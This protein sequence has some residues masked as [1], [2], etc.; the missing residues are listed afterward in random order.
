[1]PR[2][3]T[4]PA[5][6]TPFIGRRRAL[7]TLAD[8]FDRG[9]RLVSIV[10]AGGIGKTRLSVEYG[11][12]RAERGDPVRFCELTEQH[13]AEG[14]VTAVARGVGARGVDEDEVV[15]ALRRLRRGLLILDNF[16][17]L[18]AHAGLLAGWLERCPE[19]RVLVTSREVLRLEGEVV[20]ELGPL[21]LS[22]PR[23]EDRPS[24]ALMLWST[25]RQRIDPSYS[26]AG[27]DTEALEEI[28]RRLDGIPLAIELAAARANLM[29]TPQLRDRLNRR[30]DV[31]RQR[32][33][34][35]S[36][37]R[38]TMEGAL[39]WSWD[40]L[41][42]PE[43]EA[44]AQCS[45][46]RGGFSLDA[47]EAVIDLRDLPELLPDL[48]DLPDLPAPEDAPPVLDVLQAL[49]DKS[50][51]RRMEDAPGRLTMYATIRDYGARKLAADPA[52]RRAAER[53]HG[54]FFAAFGRRLVEASL[55]TTGADAL[56]E[57]AADLDNLLAVGE[58]AVSREAPDVKEVEDALDAAVAADA[59]FSTRGPAGGHQELLDALVEVAAEVDA[60]AL[61]R[62]RALRARGLLL[63][64][65]GRIAAGR[66]DLEAAVELAGAEA[67]ER[68]R[69]LLD[70]SWTYLRE[71]DLDRVEALG[72]EA[73]ELARAAGDRQLEGMV[74]GALG[75]PPK[76]RG[77]DARAADLYG[78][79]LSIHRETGNRWYEGLAHTRL[80]ILHLEHGDVDRAREHAEEAL[81]VHREFGIRVAEALMLQCLGGTS[82]VQGQLEEAR[83]CY[84]ESAA[85]AGAIGDPR[86]RGTGLGYRAVAEIEL[87][88]LESAR[89][90]LEAAYR[91]TTEV[92]E[93]RHAALYRAYLGAIEALAGHPDEAAAQI[94]RAR[95]LLAAHPDSK[96]EASV[97]VLA[98]LP[99]ITRAARGE[100]EARA[101]AEATLE[102]AL[103]PR[104]TLAAPERSSADV[105]IAL[106]I[107]RHALDA[108]DQAGDSDEA[109][110]VDPSGAWF[111]PPDGERVDCRRRQA[112]RR[113][114]VRLARQ[115]VQ[116]PGSPIAADA[117]IAAGWPDEKMSAASAQNRLYVTINRLRQLGL[118]E[119]LQL[120][121]GGY[122]LDPEVPL[123]LVPE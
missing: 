88:D 34:D 42:P 43:R 87:G 105:R 110:R 95:Q 23:D 36:A 77:D 122:R 28:V 68:S 11:R 29:S 37:R 40:L 67:A 112:L 45:V 6:T 117:L 108:L 13:D 79:A 120:V 47:A 15:A 53:R 64:R 98:A 62:A 30:F 10:G 41:E 118:G 21:E 113:I 115:R 5:P 100:A 24:E 96:L 123:A 60:G 4:L 92:G 22:A 89:E 20:L 49:R 107:V 58:R 35:R 32:S 8:L 116:Q 65:R 81:T 75:A 17:Q 94:Q 85:M 2:D 25:A 73:L 121:E 86:L 111:E 14:L 44:L 50:L 119:H 18:A 38:A 104:G 103:E 84:A 72:R 70:L 9:E 51:L 83:D 54:A 69:A 1:V 90:H 109:L 55:G 7:R 19:L 3:V 31:L 57:L 106:R 39:D 52:R 74:L 16:E 102:R 91:A 66:R 93:H 99:E 82:H 76:E 63:A 71:R 61:A 33:R 26:T 12:R 27:D 80:A 114:L 78:R 101:E 48:P 59:V 97:D 46:F 56:S